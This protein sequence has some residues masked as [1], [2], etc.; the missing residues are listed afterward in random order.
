[1]EIAQNKVEHLYHGWFAVRN[2]ST[3][4]IQDGVTMQQRHLN[5]KRF[6]TTPPWNSLPKTR[7]GVPALKKFLGKLLYDHIKD[8]F[9]ALVHE[10]R[11]LVTQCRESL[12]ALGPSRQTT[13]QQRQYLSR[14]AGRYQQIVADSLRGNYDETWDTDDI[15]KLRMH[16]QLK[17]EQFTKKLRKKGHSRAFRTSDDTA[18]EG[19]EFEPDDEESIYDWIRQLYR[20]SRGSELPG[21][22]NPVVVQNLF[23]QQ[24]KQWRAIS[25]SHLAKIDTLISEFNQSVFETIFIEDDVRQQMHN[26]NQGPS[27]FARNAAKAELEK[28]LADELCG[29]LQTTNHYYADNLA[30]ARQDRVISRLKKM[31]FSDDN[32]YHKV[33][34]SQLERVTHLSNED[35]AVFDIHDILKAYYKVAL[36]R[37]TDSVVLQ[38]IERCYFGRGGPV[39]LITPEYIGEFSDQDLDEVAHE[40]YDTARARNDNGTRLQRL[41]QALTIA[42]AESAR[43]VRR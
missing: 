17:N 20:E 10:L 11:T 25:E 8:E 9:P 18:N 41:E 33:T 40:T 13:V 29:I 24:A 3:Q 16:V 6:F 22:V 35:Q 12:D 27:A 2:R 38:A 4:D 19:S 32:T 34:L 7:T 15:R 28:L 43:D 26:R 39:M 42:E 37:F 36:K 23:R 14:L 30:A 1:M 21:T 31:G 5:E